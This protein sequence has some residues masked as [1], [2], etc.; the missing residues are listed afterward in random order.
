KITYRC[1]HYRLPCKGACEFVFRLQGYVNFVPHTCGRSASTDTALTPTVERDVSA[2]MKREVDRT[3][4]STT[5]SRSAIWDLVRAQFC[6]SADTSVAVV[7]LSRE[8]VIPRVNRVRAEEFGGSIYGQI[9]VAPWRLATDSNFPLF[10]YS[11]YDKSSKTRERILGWGHPVL[12]N[13]FKQKKT[14]L[15]VDGT[16]RCVL[17]K[18]KQCIVFTTY[19]RPTK[20]YYP[21][22]FVLATS[23]KY[24]VYFNAIWHVLDATDDAMDSEFVY[25]EFEAGL[26]RAVGD[27]FPSAATMGCLFHFKQA[28]RRRPDPRS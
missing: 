26:I 15:F 12:I 1:S 17:P 2:E 4:I 28:C 11:Y 25:C 18:F 6:G 10:H 19:D 7:G 21:C 16:L 23:K 14:S 13:M 22:A 8:Y 9:E 27:F 20:G 5:I 3:A 24:T